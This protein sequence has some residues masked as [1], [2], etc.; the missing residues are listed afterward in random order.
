M[1]VVQKNLTTGQSTLH[2]IQRAKSMIFEG[3][4]V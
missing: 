3:A 4:G 1:A 2:E